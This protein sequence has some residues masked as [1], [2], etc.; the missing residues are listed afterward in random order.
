[1]TQ[2]HA[3]R[4]VAGSARHGAGW[5]AEPRWA[6]GRA[7][8]R[9]LQPWLLDQG[10]LTA[11]LVQASR[12]DFRVS[13]RHQGLARPRLSERRALGL[14]AG[15]W[16]LVRE[17]VLWGE[18]QPWVFAR[19]VIPLASLTGRLRQLRRLQTRPLGGFLFA[20]PDLE[21]GP[22]E[23]SR[24]SPHNSSVPA[25]LQGDEPL[26]GRR[27]IFRLEARP[28]LVSE[29]FLPAFTQRLLSMRERSS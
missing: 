9:H 13:V 4:D 19:S 2:F 18:G 12:G 22:M 26:W 17:V 3:A 11:K 28:L 20:Q 16:A 21:R 1:M 25:S 24:M 6:P 29:V 8:P 14:G 27:S 15:R 7:G 10:S 5:P 23:L